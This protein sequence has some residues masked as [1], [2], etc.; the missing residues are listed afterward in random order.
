MRKIKLNHGKIAL[1]DDCDYVEV[2]KYTWWAERGRGTWYVKGWKDGKNIR[3][4]R[5]ILGVKDPSTPVDH[6]NRN[7][8]DNRRANI[9]VSTR[10]QNAANRSSQKK[11]I[12]VYF[13]K[14]RNRWFAQCRKDGKN[15]EK[16]SCKTEK[17]AALAYNFLATKL[18]GEF[19][20]LNVVRH[21]QNQ[22]R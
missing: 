17:E 14:S 18:H 1:I 9:R 21:G 20:R 4:H 8:L 22:K 13:R 2:K 6:K 7:G 11:Y 10:S 5:F 16:S 3:L 15:H 12:G 19:A